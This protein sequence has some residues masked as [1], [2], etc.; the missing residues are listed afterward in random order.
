MKDCASLFFQTQEK[1]QA[2]RFCYLLEFGII[3]LKR[4]K[5][6]KKRVG[7]RQGREQLS[8]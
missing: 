1:G 2:L 8:E 3:P 5:R 7:C 4:K 6:D